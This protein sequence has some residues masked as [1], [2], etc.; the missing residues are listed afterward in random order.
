MKCKR[1]IISRYGGPEVL[2]VIE[3]ELPKPQPGEVRVKV[4]AAGVAWG[5]ILKR[6]GFG[7][8]V[9]PPI[10]PGYDIVGIVDELGTD[11]S[12]VDVGQR[13][14]ALPVFGGYAEFLCLPASKLVQ[15]PAGLDSAEAVCLVMNYV[16]AYQLL[17]RAARVKSRER[18]LVHSAAGGIGTALLQLGRLNKLEM[19]GTASGSKQETLANLGAAPVDYKTENFVKRVISLTGDGVDVVFDPIGG[20]HIWSSYQTLRKGG[21]LIIYGAHAVVEDGMSKLVI[22]SLLSWFLKLIPDKRAILNYSITRPKYSSPEWCRND[23]VELFNI[24]AQG[25]IKPIIAE[26]IPLVEASRAHELLEKGTVSGKLVLV[27]K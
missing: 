16:V 15:V 25:K 8:G 13:V 23:L 11:V 22:G 20:T 12:T 17:H 9:H 18:I 27:S 1:V 24:L 2:Q 4:L 26:R 14:A 19:Y 3:D 21:R 5:D 6:K 7:L 10:T